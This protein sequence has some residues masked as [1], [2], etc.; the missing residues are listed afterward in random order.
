M[1]SA[2]V[3]LPSDSLD[4]QPCG[5]VLSPQRSE[6]LQALRCLSNVT[7]IFAI[8]SLSNHTSLPGAFHMHTDAA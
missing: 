3:A 6:I 2:R 5:L 1:S 8:C 4:H 7:S